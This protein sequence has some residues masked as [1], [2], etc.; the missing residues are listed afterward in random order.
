METFQLIALEEDSI[1]LNLTK[2]ENI[3]IERNFMINHLR[4]WSNHFDIS[5]K[6]LYI[7]DCCEKYGFVEGKHNIGS[8][9]RFLADMLEE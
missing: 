1:N 6:E 7:P 3:N 5:E 4:M 9:I 8:I 2:E